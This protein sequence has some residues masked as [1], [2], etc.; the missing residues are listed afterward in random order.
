MSMSKELPP[1]THKGWFGLCP[2][3]FAEL[4]S[5]APR[6][7]ERHWSLAPLMVLSEILFTACFTV[8]CWV[9]PTFEPQW[10]LRVTG[11][12]EKQTPHED[13]AGHGRA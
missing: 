10:P 9:D 2:V 7:V 1:L 6:V 12:I 13:G 5:A 11:E 3:Y 4:D 8:C